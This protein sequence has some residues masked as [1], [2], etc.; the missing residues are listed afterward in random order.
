MWN[1]RWDTGHGRPTRIQGAAGPGGR[2]TCVS[3][4]E[5][6]RRISIMF[7]CSAKT[8]IKERGKDKGLERNIIMDSNARTKI[9]DE[10][11]DIR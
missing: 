5:K 6:E 3:V 2:R 7:G 4:M 1:G 9:E 10:E 11:A 8:R